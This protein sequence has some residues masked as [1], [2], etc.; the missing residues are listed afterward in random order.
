MRLWFRKPKAERTMDKAKKIVIEEEAHR[1]NLPTDWKPSRGM[2]TGE[3]G[4]NPLNT[5][6]RVERHRLKNMTDV[7][8]DAWR[9]L[10]MDYQHVGA[11]RW[12]WSPKK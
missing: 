10:H 4:N 6:I 11:G 3:T 12:E 5:A 2:G 8:Y 9:T 7:E 1:L